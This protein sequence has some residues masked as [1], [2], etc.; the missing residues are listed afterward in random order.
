M[1]Q[2]RLSFPSQITQGSGDAEQGGWGCEDKGRV[3]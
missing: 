1:G 3:G 2:E